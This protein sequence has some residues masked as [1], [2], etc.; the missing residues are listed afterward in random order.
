MIVQQRAIVVRRYS[1]ASLSLYSRTCAALCRH[2]AGTTPLHLVADS[3]AYGARVL[4]LCTRAL[5]RVIASLVNACS[6]LRRKCLGMSAMAYIVTGFVV[7]VVLG[8]R[9]LMECVRPKE[10]VHALQ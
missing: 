4:L 6:V 7:Q 10:A 9:S 1:R 8:Q 2:C 5:L 3:T